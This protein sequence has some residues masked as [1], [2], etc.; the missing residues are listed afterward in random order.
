MKAWNFKESMIETELAARGLLDRETLPDFPYRDD[1][2]L[3][4]H[5]THEWVEAF[6]RTYYSS[7]Q[8]VVEDVELQAFFRSVQAQDGGRIK[9]VG[10]VRSIHYLI[11]ALTHIIFTGS[12]QHAAVNFPQLPI[13]SYAPAYPLCSFGAP[14]RGVSASEGDYLAMLPAL[15]LAQFQSTLG[16]LLGSLHHTQLGQYHGGLW[17]H[18]AGDHRLN[19]ALKS[20]QN[21][22]TQIEA[23]IGER[24]RSRT[25]YEFLLPSK[26]PQSINI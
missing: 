3:V 16:F 9:G 5:A 11:D 15:D 24:N 12:S 2:L 1:G 4:W 22:L 26:I 17:S 7:D 14:P 6:V 23:L 18:F 13:M 19:A 10:Q 20:F 8:A 21:H 25:S